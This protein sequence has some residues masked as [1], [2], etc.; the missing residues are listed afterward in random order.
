MGAPM[1]DPDTI[2]AEIGALSRGPFRQV[3]ARL[4]AC[5]PSDEA[6]TKQAENHPDRWGQTV[7]LIA[8]LGGFNEKLEIEGT[9]TQRVEGMS[10]AQLLVEI[11]ALKQSLDTISNVQG[12]D[13]SLDTGVLG[14]PDE[15]T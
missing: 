9:L 12:L 11:T 6:I 10:D 1:L 5:A 14:L 8:R 4:L 15:G 3:L 13:H 2:A 7:A